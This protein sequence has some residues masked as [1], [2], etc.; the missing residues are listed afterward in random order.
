MSGI[1]PVKK[2]IKKYNFMGIHKHVLTLHLGD[3]D[4]MLMLMNAYGL[5]SV[6]QYKRRCAFNPKEQYR[7]FTSKGKCS[8][9]SEK[10]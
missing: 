4:R 5:L 6:S 1:I 2:I 3:P 9:H 10:D 8:F 7:I